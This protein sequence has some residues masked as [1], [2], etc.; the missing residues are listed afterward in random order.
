MLKDDYT[1][2]YSLECLNDMIAR[3]NAEGLLVVYNHPVW[4]Q[5][6][7]DD[8]IGLKGLWGIEVFNTGS[9]VEG[10]I[11]SVLPADE[12]L[13][14]GERVVLACTDDMHDL[15]H[16]FGGWVMLKAESLTYDNIFNAMR[17][18]N[19]Y[20]STGPEINDLYLEDDKLC[21]KTSA[22]REILLSSERRYARFV[23]GAN[24]E[25]IN[26]AE[27]DIKGY[28]EDSIKCG[29]DPKKAYLRI[30]VIDNNG[31][32]AYTRAYYLDELLEK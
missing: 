12:L 7:R 2:D 8:Y 21:I 11:E 29:S 22:V 4:S 32:C 25:L 16:A 20:S 1:H 24:G 14:E 15:K 6:T 30:T 18:K 23:K 9:Y 26:G 10:Y 17:D 19:L 13:R 31:K 3:A 28:I 5:Q 27:F